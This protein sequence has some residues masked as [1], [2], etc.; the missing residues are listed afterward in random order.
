M[1]FNDEN[2]KV[3]PISGSCNSTSTANFY[4]PLAGGVNESNLTTTSQTNYIP[5]GKIGRVHSIHIISAVAMGIT[6]ISFYDKK[7]ASTF[8]TKTVTLVAGLNHI[9]FV[10]GM[11]TGTNNFNGAGPILIGFNPTTGG[12]DIFYSAIFERQLF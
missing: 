6:V 5:N 7:A 12:T 9:N 4:I 10:E 1:N 11:D 8:G 3:V 2:S